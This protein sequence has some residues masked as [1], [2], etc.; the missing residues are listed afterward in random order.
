MRQWLS[1]PQ[2]LYGSVVLV[3]RKYHLRIEAVAFPSFKQEMGRSREEKFHF[4]PCKNC[5]IVL[6]WNSAIL[7]DTLVC[8]FK[9]SIYLQFKGIL[10]G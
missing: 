7:R 5:T 3:P 1:I 6:V 4:I 10:Y 2:V 8:F 9:A